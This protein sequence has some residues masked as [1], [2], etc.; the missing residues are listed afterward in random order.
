MP[1]R[2]TLY[3]SCSLC[4]NVVCLLLT[5]LTLGHSCPGV[6]CSAVN[7]SL[8]M[9]EPQGTFNTVV[10]NMWPKSIASLSPGN[11]FSRFTPD[12]LNQKLW[13]WTLQSVF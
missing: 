9:Y 12:L 1:L 13:R 4:N 8:W 2:V 11:L 6:Q 10:L 7:Q 5:D 3:L